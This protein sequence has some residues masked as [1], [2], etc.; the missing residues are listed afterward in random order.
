MFFFGL[1][2]SLISCFAC[3]MSA[4]SGVHGDS[5]LIVSKPGMPAGV[6]PVAG[7]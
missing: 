1:A 4:D 7:S 6:M 3:S 5:G 2:T